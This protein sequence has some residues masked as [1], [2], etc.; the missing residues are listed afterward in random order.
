MGSFHDRS[1]DGSEASKERELITC[2][3]RRTTRWRGLNANI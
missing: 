2:F 3:A 1:R